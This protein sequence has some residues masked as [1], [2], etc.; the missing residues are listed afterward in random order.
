MSSKQPPRVQFDFEPDMPEVS[1]DPQIEMTNDAW[2]MDSNINGGVSMEIEEGDAPTAMPDLPSIE[3]EEIQEVEI[4]DMPSKPTVRRPRSTREP[5]AQPE[6][7]LIPQAAPV[8]Q[9]KPRKPMSEAHKAKLAI[10]REKALIARRQ[11]KEERA[12]AK[13]LE[14]EEKEL[15][16][17]QKV[18]RV[19][20]LKEEVEEAPA[21]APAPVQKD[22]GTWITK[23]DLEEAQLTAILNYE[24]LRKAR[25]AEKQKQKAIEQQK[26][27][28]KNMLRKNQPQ[29]YVYRDGSN[30]WDMCY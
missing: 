29:S 4:F 12:K 11:K 6:E 26:Q 28:M 13:A 27:Q 18:K 5:V 19:Q 16:K 20:K 21:P 1:C 7:Q 9:K 2:E 15:L 25:K 10:A 17:K 30:R 8:K 23:K 14:N 3:R 22:S 24:T